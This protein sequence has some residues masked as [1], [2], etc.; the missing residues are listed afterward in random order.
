MADDRHRQ[1]PP[2][3]GRA[4]YVADRHPG[5]VELDLAELLCD[6]TDHL[7]RPLH[8]PGLMHRHDERRNA[9]VLGHI[10]V[11]A[12]QHQTPVGHIGVA[13]PDLVPRN[14][15]LVAVADRGRRQRCQVRTRARLTEALTPALGAIDHSGQE[16]LPQFLIPVMAQADDEIPQTRPRGRSGLGDLLVDDHVIHRRKVLSAIRLRPRRTE[17][18][19]V[20]QRNVPV[21]RLGPVLVSRGG[22][23][24]LLLGQPAAQPVPER[25]LLRRITKVQWSAPPASPATPRSRRAPGAGRRVRDTPTCYRYR[26]APESTSHRSS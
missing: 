25:G 18:A 22:E 17:E 24:A 16:P 26:H 2:V 10:L 3:A 1:L 7:Q 13:G 8:Y 12:C 6:A 19:R 5:A 9:L 20:V 4:D 21:T 14:D 15:V 23:L 11:R